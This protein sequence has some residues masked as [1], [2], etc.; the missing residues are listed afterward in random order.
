ML[1]RIGGCACVAALLLAGSSAARVDQAGVRAKQTVRAIAVLG[2]RVAGSA[3]ELRA[4][5]VVRARFARPELPRSGPSALAAAAAYVAASAV[6]LAVGVR[7][8]PQ[9]LL[10]LGAALVAAAAGFAAAG[11]ART[12]S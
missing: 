7:A 1:V 8:S 9:A 10:W 3:S 4:A 6:L 11:R 2:P 5:R 12:S